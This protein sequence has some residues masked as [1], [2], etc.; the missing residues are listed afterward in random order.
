[1]IP[2][3]TGKWR[4]ALLMDIYMIDL[5]IGSEDITEGTEENMTNMLAHITKVMLQCPEGS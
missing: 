4:D 3:T 2:T 5:L 1:M